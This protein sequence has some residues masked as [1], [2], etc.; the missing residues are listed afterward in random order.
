VFEELDPNGVEPFKNSRPDNLKAT[1]AKA[2]EERG[3]AHSQA[4]VKKNIDDY[5]TE[6]DEDIEAA[7]PPGT[8]IKEVNASALKW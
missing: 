2:M 3:K 1:L 7:L 8:E 4:R 6:K 5:M